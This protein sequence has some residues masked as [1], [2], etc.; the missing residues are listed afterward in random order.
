MPAQSVLI[1]PSLPPS[2]PASVPGGVTPPPPGP[3]P[4]P[5]PPP[6]ATKPA[7]TRIQP[8]QRMPAPQLGRNGAHRR[9]GRLAH[10]H[11]R[12]VLAF[13]ARQIEERLQHVRARHPPRPGG[14]L[15]PPLPL[16]P[17]PPP[18]AQLVAD[19][20]QDLKRSRRVHQPQA[21]Q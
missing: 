15:P 14:A 12:Q 21:H 17:Y 10:G 3:A 6:Q 19:R 7:I 9:Q 2:G 5:A 8:A 11:Q 16:N 13:T 18:P 20:V 1:P 4:P